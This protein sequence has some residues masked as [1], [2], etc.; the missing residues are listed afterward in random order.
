MGNAMPIAL[1]TTVMPGGPG[2]GETEI[3]VESPLSPASRTLIA[4]SQSALEEIYP[5]HQIFSLAPEELATPNT[6]FFVART[7]RRP[8]GCV[9]LV[10]CV[11][12]GEVKRLYVDPA[13]RGAGVGRALMLALERAASDIG[14]GLLRLETGPELASA[15]RI[16]RGLGYIERDAFGGYEDAPC[17]LFMEKRLF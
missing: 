12:Y 2:L 15:V 4:G 9:A 7:A 16:Y 11:D 8:A 5:P 1:N 14:L 6:M 10:D 17:S 13:L 3:R